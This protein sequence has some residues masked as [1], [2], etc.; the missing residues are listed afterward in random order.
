MS[1]P[2]QQQQ[3]SQY[4]VTYDEHGRPFIVVRDQG[5]QKRVTGLE[6]HKANIM[7]ATAVASVMRSSLGPKGMDKMIVSGD[8]DVT[9]TN[10]GATI[11]DQMD[12]QHEIGKLLVQLS[13][14][15]DDEIGDGTTGVVVLAGALLE[16]AQ[17]LLDK[18]IHAIRVAKGF[19]AA[20]NV[21]VAHLESIS[22]TFEFSADNI[23]PLITTAMTTLGSK[24]VNRYHRPLAEIAVKAVL[25]VADLE[26]REV[27]FDMIRMEGKTGGL[28]EDTMMVEGVLLDKSMSHPQMPKVLKNVK[29]A[30]LTCAF[31]APKPKTGTKLDI[32]SAA[33]Y[34]SLLEMEQKYYGDMVELCKASGA[35]L[36][37]CQWGFEDECNHLLLQKNLPAVRWVGGVELELIAIA[38]NARIIPRFEEITPEK[39]GF[40]GSVRE[41]SFGTTKDTMLA[42]E[43]CP[44]SK[45]TTIF[46][47]GGNAQMVEEAK[48]S[49]HDALCV[50]RNLVTSNKVVYGGG[51]AEVSCALRIR[52]E[53]DKH[54]GLEQYGIR[55][56]A[57][58]LE[59]IPKALAENS[60]L[61]PIESLTAMKAEQLRTGKPYLGVDCMNAG[62]LD[63]KSQGVYESL[64]G[65][66]QQFL[67]ATQLA[68]MILKIDDVIEPKEIDYE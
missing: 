39:L 34:Q 4:P 29:V 55:A 47:R 43:G 10:D 50:T 11:L 5:K 1:V 58:A 31:E 63:M 24:I 13:K 64:I 21:A 16:K 45:A 8:N 49:I 6:A 2:G 46:V 57:D 44:N 14:A 17:T 56:F 19:D 65:K 15:Q 26:R 18:G 66:R 25:A 42:I 59:M 35:E 28:L 52:E 20:V 9:V 36:V 12:V 27:N 32:T 51:S 22:D 41:I 62:T 3:Q 53:A 7:A 30:L 68:K 60:G 33:D 48:R 67:L 37:L 54:A 61:S 23:E 38:T 40:A